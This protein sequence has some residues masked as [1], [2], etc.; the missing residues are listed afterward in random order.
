MAL[1]MIDK[2]TNYLM[3][4]EGVG[5]QE[6]QVEEVDTAQGSK[7]V[8]LSVHS[9]QSAKLKVLIVSAAKYD[10]VRKYADHLKANIAVVINLVGVDV[11]TQNAIKDFMNGVCYIVAGNVQ[12][13]ADCVFMYTPADVDIEKELYAYSVP[14]YVKPKFE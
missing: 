10:D 12:R 7:L 8:S 4:V 3:P 9:N 13:I 5:H 6:K 2:L 1:S 11:D 14:A